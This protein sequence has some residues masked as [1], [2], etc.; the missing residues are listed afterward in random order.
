MKDP[1]IPE[2]EPLW[3][4]A[5]QRRRIV[6]TNAQ[7]Q[8][9]CVKIVFGECFIRVIRHMVVAAMNGL[10]FFFNSV[11]TSF[12]VNLKASLGLVLPNQYCLI[13]VKEN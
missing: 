13:T 2:T 3:A 1:V 10:N 12:R 11:A 8:C 4:C 9:K 5:F 6:L 7:Y